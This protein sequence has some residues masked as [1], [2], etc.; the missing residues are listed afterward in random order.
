MNS[1]LQF[2]ERLTKAVELSGL[3]W[4]AL[5]EKLSEGDTR[6]YASTTTPWRD[7]AMPSGEM[8]MRLPKVLGVD[9][10]WLLTGEGAMKPRPPDRAALALA[11]IEGVVDAA[12]DEEA[13]NRFYGYWVA[14][15]QLSTSEDEPAEG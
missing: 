15:N 12:A 7:G 3:T 14:F 1:K 13:F 8:L 5:A 9:G 10:H 6:V 4:N 11:L 2:T